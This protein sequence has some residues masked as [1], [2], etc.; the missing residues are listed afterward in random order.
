MKVLGDLDV[1]GQKRSCH[2]AHNLLAIVPLCSTSFTPRRKNA[3]DKNEQSNRKVLD[4]AR[5][6]RMGVRQG[7]QLR[8]RRTFMQAN[9]ISRY[10]GRI[11]PQKRVTRKGEGQ[12]EK[13][14]C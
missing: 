12:F 2:W 6:W 5:N 10:D 1:S 3:R 7:R 4:A 13:S 11:V 9:K 8:A 14:L